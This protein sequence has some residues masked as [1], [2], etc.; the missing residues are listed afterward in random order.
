MASDEMG[1]FVFSIIFIIVFSTLL[2]SIPVG[3]QGIGASPDTVIP[4]N[5]SLVTDFVNGEDFTRTDF[6]TGP[7]YSYLYVLGGRSW[8]C[9]TVD[10]IDFYLS[11][12]ILIGGILWLGGLDDCKFISSEG[13]DRGTSINFTEID[14][15]ADDGTI[16][17]SL[18][19][20][21][22]GNDAGGFVFYWNTT[23]YSDSSDAWD[24]DA[25]YFLHGVGFDASATANIGALI[26]SLLFLQLPNVPVLVNMFL[27]VPIWAC[28]VFVLWFVIK[29][30]IP[31][32]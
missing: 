11:A 21:D 18:K 16:R 6:S 32:V 13:E 9:Y 23:T 30:M 3:L 10:N 5:P 14:S 26:V 1:G 8:I 15:D 22:T 25:L 19:Y 12:K 7:P 28:I 29:E 4:V 27:A 17:Y 24:A 20:I 2:S 31:F